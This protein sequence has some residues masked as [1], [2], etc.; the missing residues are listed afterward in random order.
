MKHTKKVECLAFRQSSLQLG[1]EIQTE[2]VKTGG[3]NPWAGLSEIRILRRV[4]P[5]EGGKGC[6]KGGGEGEG[7][8]NEGHRLLTSGT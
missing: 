3:G 7:G 2:G 1:G 5:K 8:G 4:R 6:Q